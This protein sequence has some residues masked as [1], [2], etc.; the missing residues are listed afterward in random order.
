[1]VEFETGQVYAFDMVNGFTYIGRVGESE[2]DSPEGDELCD[3]VTTQTA[4]THGGM[5]WATPAK[6][7]AEVY[8]KVT[9][10][11]QDNPDRNIKLPSFSLEQIASMSVFHTQIE[12]QND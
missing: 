5:P 3:V 10:Y 8:K 9:Q 12:I 11:I 1:M 4:F 2:A 6:E 7:Y